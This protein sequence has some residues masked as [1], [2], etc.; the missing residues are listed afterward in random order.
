MTLLFETPHFTLVADERGFVRLT[1]TGAR[2]E[3]ANVPGVLDGVLPALR[4]A[5]RDAAA[6]GILVDVRFG[7]AN[8]DP[9]FEVAMN[10]QM[11]ALVRHFRRYAV[12]VKTAAGVLQVNRLVRT[13]HESA[14]D[15]VF[16]DEDQAIA[17][18][19]LH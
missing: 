5:G 17:F 18:L 4:A 10:A 6:L 7:P 8:N 14:E 2:L 19:T 1:R 16:R 3:S 9:A 15:H 13:V 12:V 11:V